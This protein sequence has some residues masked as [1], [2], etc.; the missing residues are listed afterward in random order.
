VIGQQ[1]AMTLAKPLG[2][3]PPRIADALIAT[4]DL[5]SVG[6]TSADVAGPD[7]STSSRRRFLANG[8]LPILRAPEQWGRADLGHAPARCR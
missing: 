7:S 6:V 4:M 2:K 8:L 1:L 3:K 5:P